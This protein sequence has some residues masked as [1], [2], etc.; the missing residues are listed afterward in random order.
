MKGE[1]MGD[2]EN[3]IIGLL[4]ELLESE[5]KAW[6]TMSNLLKER[7]ESGDIVREMASGERI[8]IPLNYG[9][10]K[11]ESQRAR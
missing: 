3:V 11:A 6:E 4:D 5:I 2:M 1:L 9:K 7:S 8:I 10:P